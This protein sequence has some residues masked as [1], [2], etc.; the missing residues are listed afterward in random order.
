[1]AYV[2]YLRSIKEE[3]KI[4]GRVK[5]TLRVKSILKHFGYLRR[6]QAFINEFN[7]ALDELGMYATPD[8]DIYLPLESKVT[9]AIKGAAEA[10]S[11]VIVTPY[12]SNPIELA[13]P[14]Q[15][16]HDFFYYLFDFGSEQEYEQF[17]AC[18]DSNQPMGLFLVPLEQDFFSEVVVKVLTY[19]LVR[20]NQ[21]KGAGATLKRSK[22]A[23][24]AVESDDVSDPEGLQ[25]SLLDSNIFH[26]SE[27]TMNNVILGSTGLELLDSEKFDEQLEQLSLRAHKY[28]S[29]QLF[30]LFHCP[31]EAQI[32]THA[33]SDLFGHLVEKVASQI[34]FTFTLRCKYPDQQS[35]QDLDAIYAHFRLLLEVPKHH[36][37]EDNAE[38]LD[39]F[40][41]LHKT[42]MQSELQILLQMQPDHFNVLIW[43]HESD[44]H[45][46]L[47]YFAIRTLEAL[48]YDLSQIHCE[49][50]VSGNIAEESQDEESAEVVE[51][52]AFAEDGVRRRPDVYVE[53]KLIVEVETLRGK[54]FNDNNVFLDLIDRI[55]AKSVGWPSQLQTVW[56]VLPGF[57]IARNYYQLKKVQEILEHQLRAE[58]TNSLQLL[59]MVPDYENHQLIPVSFKEIDYPSFKL[60]PKLPTPPSPPI[61]KTTGLSFDQVKGL[62]EE[63]EKLGKI[64]RLQSK[65]IKSG[66]GGILLFGLP[67][68]G[69]TLLANA[70]A[71]ESG[72]Y[73]FKFS[74]ADIQSMWISQ[75]QKNVKDIFAQDKKKSPSVLFIDELDSIGFSRNEAQAHTDQKATI[76][77]LLI[78]LNNAKDSDVIVIA[79]TNCLSRI[80]SALK[81]SGRLDWKIP[82]FPPDKLER[83]A[84]FRHYLSQIEV[85]LGLVNCELLAEQSSRFTSSDIELVCREVRNAVLL[86]E[87]SSN[88]TTADLI[89]YITNVQDGGLTLDAT[90]V[91]EFLD[92]CRSL[93]VRSPK[94]DAL[95]AEWSI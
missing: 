80:D 65:G 18:L 73:F 69:K 3:L 22:L 52:D 12:I 79:A 31:S 54:G 66:I 51:S 45:I 27:S 17:Q 42:Q 89:T 48:G 29:D 44:E 14:L 67:G 37:E 83:A 87:I 63:K 8:F 16:K 9:I 53:D 38:L 86:E 39:Y 1:M 56:L 55:I 71:N 95:R 92:E 11:R 10:P 46:Y 5:K 24:S 28:N 15:V 30:V 4:S 78:E 81:R 2:A 60:S 32:R 61:P 82:L 20:K 7:S 41:E 90:Q 59:V 88:V 76:N 13:S 77:Q 6:S 72:R 33:R 47:K 19:E 25:S 68:C 50:Q 74:P 57:E 21:Y 40:L 36:C 58:C 35:I 64:L 49:L 93:S 91:Q 26:F 75:S 70:F 23:F 34:P 43:G 62:A 85:S 94:I 84:L